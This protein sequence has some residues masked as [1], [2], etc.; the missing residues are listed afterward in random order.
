MQTKTV[1]GYFGKPKQITR[2]D[3]IKRW[4][5]VVHDCG[6]LAITT[7]DWNATKN[8]VAQIEAMAGRKWDAMPSEG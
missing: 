7:A 5:A 2:E 1:Q 8:M 6:S 4:V 3:F